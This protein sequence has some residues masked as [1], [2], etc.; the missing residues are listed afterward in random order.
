MRTVHKFLVPFADPEAGPLP[1]SRHAPVRLTGLDPRTGKPAVW[2]EV[3]TT[4][5]PGER[6]MAVF[7]TGHE[8]P[9][10]WVHVGS[11]IDG[12]FVWHIY[13]EALL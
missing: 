9:D 3:E 4:N 1:V 7:G 5:P 13:E 6:R 10:G 2:I 12:S 8:L 11:M